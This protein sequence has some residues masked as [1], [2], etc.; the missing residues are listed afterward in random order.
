[1]II[2]IVVVLLL[3]GALLLWF[4]IPYSPLKRAFRKDVEALKSEIQRPR[5]TEVFTVE[6]FNN[7]PIPVRNYL[8]RCGYLGTPKMSY[9]KMEYRDVAFTQARGRPPLKIDYTQYTFVDD[10]ARVAL[11][12]SS[13]FG[14]P[15]EGYD[16][17]RQ[18]VGGMKGVIAKVITLFD[19]TG[20]EMNRAALAT[21]LAESLFCPNRCVAGLSYFQRDQ[22]SSGTGNDK[23]R[24][25][26][27]ERGF[28]FQRPVRNG[29]FHDRRSGHGRN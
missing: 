21:F 13:L 5:G 8:E 6:D 12:D 17:Y 23:L 9:L 26:S 29:V 18:G 27:S 20:P 2:A 4:S 11:I 16:Y 25:H 3:V 15:F 22:R 1:M 28:Y 24:R 19:Q 10:P 14:I 7:L